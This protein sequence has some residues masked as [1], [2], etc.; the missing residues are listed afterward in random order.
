VNKE[1]F[2]TQRYEQM[3]ASLSS[4]VPHLTRHGYCTLWNDHTLG[5]RD[6]A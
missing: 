5:L 3:G 2:A 4:K 6:A 1:F